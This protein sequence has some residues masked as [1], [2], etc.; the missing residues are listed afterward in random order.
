MRVSQ[1]VSIS[2]EMNFYVKNTYLA[3]V[4]IKKIKIWEKTYLL[5]SRGLQSQ[6][7]FFDLFFDKKGQ[8]K[9]G[10]LHHKPCPLTSLSSRKSWDILGS[11]LDEKK[12]ST[13]YSENRVKIFSHPDMT[14]IPLN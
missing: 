12:F 8:F 5:G 1:N 4:N 9:K 11:Y 14:P 10:V 6:K 2:W 3:L 7:G 13:L